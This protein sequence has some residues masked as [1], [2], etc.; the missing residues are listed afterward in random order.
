M[1]FSC[2]LVLFVLLVC[3]YCGLW[4][5]GDYCVLLALVLTSGFG[6]F[7]MAYYS[8]CVLL[9]FGNFGYLNILLWFV[10]ILVYIARICC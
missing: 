4:L 9:G 6:V 8:W 5:R 7:R 3:A 10:V 2:F 1:F